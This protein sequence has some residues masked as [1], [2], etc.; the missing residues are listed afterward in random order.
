MADTAKKEAPDVAS[1]E[2]SAQRLS[3]I[4]QQLESGELSLEAS[5]QLFEEGVQVARAAQAR[6]DQAEKRVEELLGVDGKGE[7]RTRPFES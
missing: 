5:L 6:L 2:E 7:L 1:F 4:V 3:D